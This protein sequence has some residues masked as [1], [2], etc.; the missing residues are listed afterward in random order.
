MGR[1]TQRHRL[2]LLALLSRAGPRGLTREKLIGYLWPDLESDRAR[3]LLSDSAYRINAA[4]GGEAILAAGEDLR[5]NLDRVSCDVVDFEGTLERGDR[6]AAVGLYSGPF[7]DGFSLPDNEAFDQWVDAE[8][9]RLRRAYSSALEALA[10]EAERSGEPSA[11]CEWLRTLAAHE[12]YS[13]RVALRLIS[14]LESLGERAAALQFARVHE[15]MLREQLDVEPDP[16]LHAA[17]DRLKAAPRLAAA[18]NPDF[19]PGRTPGSGRESPEA[20]TTAGQRI[21][22]ASAP[23]RAPLSGRRKLAVR[24]LGGLVLIAV[25]AIAWHTFVRSPEPELPRGSIAVLPFADHGNGADNRYFAAGLTEELINTLSRLTNLQVAGRTSSFALENANLDVREVGRRL[26]VASVVE[27]SVRRSM[28]KVRI[29]VQLIDVRDGYQRWSDTYERAEI[30]VLAVQEEIARAIAQHLE[31]TL[32]PVDKRSAQAAVDS[33]SFDLY[34]SARYHWHRRGR[35]NL[36]IAVSNLERAV[37]RAPTY[38]RAWAGLA[39]AYAISGFYDYLPPRVAF[40]RAQEAAE[41]ALR[42]DPQLAAAFASLGYVELYYHWNFARSEEHFRRAIRLDPSYSTAQQWYGNLLTAAGRF[43]EAEQAMRQAR[44]LDPL[45]LIATSAAG[46]SLYYA[47]RYQDANQQLLRAIEQDST[48]QLAHLWR[49][50]VL[51][52][53]G[54]L[55]AAQASIETGVQLSGSSAIHV[56][57]LARIHALRSNQAVATKL[58]AALEKGDYGYAPP[59]EIAKVYLGLRDHERALDLLERALEERAHSMAFVLVDP[60]LDVIRMH[61]RFIRLLERVN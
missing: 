33:A 19:T 60:Q 16:E 38:A 50:A 27:G 34:L 36:A 59:Y 44:L 1:A 4:L 14:V 7:L 3:H 9:E 20:E 10:D 61:P 58:L 8:R 2:A 22:N 40:P 30:D 43:A 26:G 48:F 18:V 55:E 28:G 11:A 56:T 54:Q 35:D 23:A 45:S 57:A 24:A 42:L 49:G 53:L 47:R 46:W 13:S 41:Q 31:G 32:V 25:A 12:P 52:A 51:E 21:H 15:T 5:L 39:D 29:A 6:R 17:I 37:R